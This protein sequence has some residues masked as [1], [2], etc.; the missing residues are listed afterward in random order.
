MKIKDL[1]ITLRLIAATLAMALVMP[2]VATGETEAPN[3]V[4]IHA[5]TL[6]AE[7]GRP[8]VSP[9]TVVVEDGKIRDT[10]SGTLGPSQL[11]L[12]AE[13]RVIELGNMFVMPGFID[14]HVHL[15]GGPD[16]PHDAYI[17]HPDSYF[18]LVGARNAKRTLMAGFTTVRDLG[19]HG[20]TLFALRDAIRDGYVPGPKIIA[21]GPPISPTGG[22]AD[23]HGYRQEVLD[24]LPSPGVCN[25]ADDCRRAVRD[26]VKRGADVIKVMATGGVLD[27]SNV[28]TGQ[29]FTDEELKAI[30]ETAHMLNRKV[31]AHAHSKEGI[32]ACLRAGFDSIEHAMWADA[33]TMK[34]FN[35]T[36]AWMV[37]TVYP[38]TW[39]GDTPEKVMQGPYKNLPPVMLKKLLHLGHQPKD[40]MRLAYKMGVKIALGTDAGV[41]PHGQNAHEF[42]EYVDAG[43]SPKESL[44]AGTVNAATAGGIDGV[45]KL[46]PGMAAD[47]VALKGN[48]LQDIQAVLDVSFVMRDGIVFKQ[49]GRFVNTDAGAD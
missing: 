19:S 14:L 27:M 45:G 39:V 9:A 32:E 40:M 17:K 28:G 38:I 4:V 43:M 25:G 49:D 12:P 35:K 48:P 44:M 41:Y 6:L 10:R 24:A 47:L 13:T 23:L 16:I 37:P 26:L 29:Q 22:H 31:T 11:G 2:S 15:S 20:D 3:A 18:A 46:A 1:S 36:G 5:G 7:P 34:L 8:P 42:V 21:S 33:E 30:A